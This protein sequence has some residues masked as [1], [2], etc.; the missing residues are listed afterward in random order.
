[1]KKIPKVVFGIPCYDHRVAIEFF[2][3]AIQTEVLLAEKGIMHTYMLKP[4]DQFIA[5]VRSKIASEFLRDHPDATHLFFLDD[6]ISWP[7]S[8]VIEFLERDEDILAGIYPKKQEK[9]DFPVE[10]EGNVKTGELIEKDGL[11]R[12]IAVPTGFMCIRRNVLEELS[13]HAGTFR[14]QDANDQWHEYSYI[15]RTAVT[16]D[17]MFAGEDYVMCQNARAAGFEIWVDPAIPFTHRGP[18]LWK[19]NLS[20]HLDVFREKGKLAAR[21]L[22]KQYAASAPQ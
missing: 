20:D 15:F 2:R 22:E 13:R 5:K 8:K 10:L 14:E 11:V 19:D 3:S 1:M 17:G 9:R 21:E 16:S 12:A 6:D 4:G 18:R 7:P